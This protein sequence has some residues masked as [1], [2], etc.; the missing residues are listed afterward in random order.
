VFKMRFPP[1][2]GRICSGATGF[3]AWCKIYGAKVKVELQS[4]WWPAR[5]CCCR[6]TCV[7]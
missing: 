2:G 7:P 6:C 5:S 1:S 3:Y 4:W